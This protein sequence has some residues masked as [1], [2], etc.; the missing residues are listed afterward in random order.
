MAIAHPGHE[1]IYSVEGYATRSTSLKDNYFIRNGKADEWAG[2]YF[3]RIQ[4]HLD[5]KETEFS[6]DAD[7]Q[8]FPPGISGIQNGKVAYTM[9]QF[10]LSA[11]DM[12]VDLGVVSNISLQS[13][14]KWSAKYDFTVI[15]LFECKE[16]LAPGDFSR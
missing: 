7:N 9:N 1:K 6:I 5:A 12:K 8:S 14:Y 13:N 11:N 4:Q 3:N 2:K 16:V 15:F 10:D